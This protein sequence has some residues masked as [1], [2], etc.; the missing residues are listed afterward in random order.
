VHTVVPAYRRVLDAYPASLQDPDRFA[1][2]KTEAVQAVERVYNRGFASGYYLGR[3]LK[4]WTSAPGNQATAR[5][6]YIGQVIKHVPAE[7]RTRIRLE[8][9]PLSVGDAV[10]VEGPETGFVPLT[11]TRLRQDG[12]EIDGGGKGDVI[13]LISDQSF[14]PADKLYRYEERA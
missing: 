8:S 4:A 6:C 7:Q 5:R 9:G 2:V 1:E 13:D 11:V 14:F 3:P 10:F 12:R